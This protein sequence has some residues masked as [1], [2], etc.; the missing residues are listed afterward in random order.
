MSSIF[1]SPRKQPAGGHR[2]LAGVIGQIIHGDAYADS[3][4]IIVENLFAYGNFVRQKPRPWLCYDCIFKK[5]NN[6]NILM[7]NTQHHPGY[8]HWLAL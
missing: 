3:P 8:K 1:G 4:A 6:A 5:T 2:G 7:P